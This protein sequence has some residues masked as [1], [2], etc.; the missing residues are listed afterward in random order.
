M[1]YQDLIGLKSWPFQRNAQLGFWGGTNPGAREEVWQ[2]SF[3]NYLHLSGSLDVRLYSLSW[4]LEISWD[5]YRLGLYQP[6]SIA[7]YLTELLNSISRLTVE[8]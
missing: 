6:P 4:D 8:F 5:C 2:L 7:T 1:Y 3:G